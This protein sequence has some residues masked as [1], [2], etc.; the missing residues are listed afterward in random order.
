MCLH[1]GR[2]LLPSDSEWSLTSFLAHRPWFCS[3]IAPGCRSQKCR[4]LHLWCYRCTTGETVTCVSPHRECHSLWPW[5]L[6]QPTAQSLSFWHSLVQR[7]WGKAP[8]PYEINGQGNYNSCGVPKNP[9]SVTGLRLNLALQRREEPT[10]M[11]VTGSQ[12]STATLEDLKTQNSQPI[13]L[14]TQE[15]ASLQNQECS[16]S[17]PR[18][19]KVGDHSD[20]SRATS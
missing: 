11:A 2:H 19:G 4:Q 5:W 14:R 3:C 1:W 10:Y 9:G 8:L 6:A 15:T 18:E 16:G 13:L 12:G 7:S 17:L 20:G